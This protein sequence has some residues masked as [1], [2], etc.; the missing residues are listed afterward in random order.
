MWAFQSH[1]TL[2]VRL[3]NQPRKLRPGTKHENVCSNEE[4]FQI[5]VSTSLHPQKIILKAAALRV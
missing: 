4:R 5:A 2:Q 1:E 3:Q